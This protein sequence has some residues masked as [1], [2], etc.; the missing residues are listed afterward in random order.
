MVL[1]CE[2]PKELHS[3]Q[4]LHP[5]TADHLLHLACEIPRAE[6]AVQEAPIVLG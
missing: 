3:V 5:P 4:L 6:E 2:G 1:R